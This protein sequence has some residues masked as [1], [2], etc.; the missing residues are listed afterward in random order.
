M[1]SNVLSFP[2][3]A[4]DLKKKNSVE[5]PEATEVPAPTP[6]MAPL[7]G[8]P[9]DEI[10]A[11]QQ[12]RLLTTLSFLQDN[13]GNTKDGLDTTT[14]QTCVE[15][16]RIALDAAMDLERTILKQTLRIEEMARLASTDQLTGVYNR[17]GFEQEFQRVLSAATRYGE[18]GVLIYID[19]DG[20]KPINDTYG[21]AAGDKMLTEV[22]RVLNDHIR[23]Q[24]MVARLGG[25]EFA[26]LLTRTDWKDGL[27]RAERIKHIL[28]THYLSWNDKHI[29]MRASLGFQCYGANADA[30]TLLAGADDAMYQS[31]R[32]RMDTVK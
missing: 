30:H 8:K 1:M 15:A 16:T 9:A 5:V 3:N 10:S 25:D 24:D 19:L 14:L 7:Q 22:A 20:F 18:T 6:S 17:R 4:W 26:I 23:P 13:L 28:N 32:M 31:K 21:H 11:N 27:K 2:M 29:A 12:A